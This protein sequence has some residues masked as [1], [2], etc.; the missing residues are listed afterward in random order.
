[1]KQEDQF[2]TDVDL[3]YGELAA[4]GP[5]VAGREIASG[6][7]PVA[8]ALALLREQSDG[9][10]T[11][12]E[13]LEW[14]PDPRVR[15]T[16]AG[17]SIIHLYQHYRGIPVFE[18]MQ[19][20]VLPAPSDDESAAQ[21]EGAHVPLPDGLPLSPDLDAPSALLAACRHLAP[22]IAAAGERVT[23]HPPSLLAVLPLAATPTLLHKLPFE[24]PVRAHLV[25]FELTGEAR[26]SWF[27]SLALTGTSGAWEVVVEAAGP[28]AGRILRSRDVVSTASPARGSIWPYEPGDPDAPA[29]RTVEF[30]VA[31]SELPAVRPRAPLPADFP[32]PWVDHR[33]T[34]GNN[35]EVKPF[36]GKLLSGFVSDGVVV[37]AAGDAQGR[38]QRILN[39]FY[40]C[41]YLHDLFY[42]LGFAEA[43]GNFQKR[44]FTGAPRAGDRLQVRIVGRTQGDAEL[45]PAQDGS[46]PRMSLGETAA[47]RHTSLSADVV[48]H[49]LVHGVT[50]RL[51]GGSRVARPMSQSFQSEALD[52]GTCDWFAL[53]VQNHARLG[54]GLPEKS[55]FGAWVADD[56]ARGL[57]PH[58]Y[59]GYPFRFGDLAADSSLRDKH[60]AGQ[61]W[62]AALLEMN[63]RLGAL[64][65]DSRQGHELGW[66][67]MV[68]ALQATPM[69]PGSITYLRMRDRI[70]DAIAAL[71][72]APPA[73]ADGSPLLPVVRRGEAVAA[74]RAAFAA[75]GMGP[76]A[77]GD[78]PRFEDAV[79][80]P[81]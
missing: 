42:L 81:P 21:I 59:A 35:A 47:G 1:M 17:R 23:G 45:V 29:R 32:P 64:L 31:L 19:T 51:V 69:T 10:A 67:A 79:S 52:E 46:S 26:L 71:G 49:E 43:G 34:S 39:A 68:D 80:D 9:S 13:V 62:C 25:Y 78:H 8:Q 54:Q 20:V 61:V 40:W 27:V 22:A 66:Q 65:E 11:R 24:D 41:N 12:G 53:T 7:S 58:P 75:F 15:V 48:I 77:A 73:R 4:A 56:T 2:T 70:L 55:V 38:D 14:V 16:S 28:Q 72:A 63:R 44:N 30:P 3:R 18:S 5:R 36:G 33:G 74:A 76:A 37:F 60:A 50:N 6:T 57:R